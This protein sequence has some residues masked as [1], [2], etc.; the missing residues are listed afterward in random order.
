MF[1]RALGDELHKRG[2]SRSSS[3]TGP[4][5]CRTRRAGLHRA[6]PDGYTICI[7][8]AEPM[9]YNQYLLKN[10]P[11]DPEK[12]WPVTNLFQI[13]QTLVVNSPQGQDHRRADRA[14]RKPSRAR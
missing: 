5:A 11:F 10:L 7:L 13:I 8:N 9:A 2:A 4:A 6:A 1:M 14:C 12:L 3:R